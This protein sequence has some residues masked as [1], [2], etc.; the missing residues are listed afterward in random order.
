MI[1]FEDFKKL[2]LRIVEIV[3][4]AVHP[5]ADKLFVV[6]FKLDGAEKQVV[7]GIRDY[8][9]PEDLVGKKVVAITNL[10]A[11]TIRGVESAG[12]ILAARDDESLSVL[13]PD[14]EVKVESKIS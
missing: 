11:A 6:K 13:V 2:D 10:K 5:N 1:S 7:A 4:A 3:D 12:M 9:K 8:Y 14:K